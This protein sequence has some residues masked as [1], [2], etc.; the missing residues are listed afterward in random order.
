MRE[1]AFE[2][3]EQL[4]AAAVEVVVEAARRAQA[5]RGKFQLALSGG[6][7]PETLFRLL[8]RERRIDWERV[9]FYQ[10]DERCLPRTSPD[11]NFGR[12]SAL[13]LT[14]L[15]IPAGQVFPIPDDWARA[16]AQYERQLPAAFDLVLLGMGGDGHIASLFPGSPALEETRRRVLR[17]APGAEV[18]PQVDRITLTLPALRTARDTLLL[19]FGE[20]KIRTYRE[21][22]A[23]RLPVGLLESGRVFLAR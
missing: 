8:A 9:Q 11:S 7:T 1:T 14:P 18:T 21:R 2:S 16:A 4:F 13:L 23:R 3:R 10:V 22:Q 12:L 6:R 15:R 20:E 5:E 19:F 17:V